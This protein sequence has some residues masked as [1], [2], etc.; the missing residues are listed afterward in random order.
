MPAQKFI[1]TRDALN[2][3]VATLREQEQ[4]EKRDEQREHPY[5]L[6]SFDAQTARRKSLFNQ[7]YGELRQG[8]VSAGRRAETG[9][10]NDRTRRTRR[11]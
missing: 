3:L 7:E 9:S 1:A 6:R 5:G 2:E 10:M 8:Q 11:L 4:P